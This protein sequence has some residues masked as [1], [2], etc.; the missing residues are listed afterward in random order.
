MK[1]RQSIIYSSAICMLALISLTSCG[2]IEQNLTIKADGSGSLETSFDVGEMMSML[3]G[4]G[5]AGIEDVTISEDKAIDTLPTGEEA[6][7]DPMQ[8]LID[9]VIDPEYAKDFD[10][11]MPLLS[12]MPDSVKKKETRPDLAEKLSLRMKSPANS[13]DLTI[14]LIM[15]FENQAQLKELVKYMETMD[16][17]SSTVMATASPG[18]M[19][20]ENFLVFNADLKAGWIRFDSVDYSGMAEEFQMSSDSMMTGEDMGMMEM[21]LGST[22]VRSIIH[23]PGEVTS[24]TNK[25][26]IITKDNK[27]IVEYGLMD[28]I[29]QGKIPGYTI[30]FTPGR[31]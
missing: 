20:A 17:S 29:K 5:D 16:N 30:H 23:V 4:F 3:K 21:M 6:P 12:L 1:I 18:G 9:K 2:D 28:A 27:V 19:T 11:I 13:S 25:E 10:T 22:K 8:L 24:C 7:K 14:G 15:K 31:S 26:A